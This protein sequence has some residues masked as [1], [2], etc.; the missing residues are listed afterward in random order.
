MIGGFA[1]GQLRLYNSE[2]GMKLVEIAAHARSITALD[3]AS[4]AAM[5]RKP[6]LTVYHQPLFSYLQLLSVSE[7]CT[8]SLWSLP[9]TNN[10][11]V[12]AIG[13]QQTSLV[14]FWVH[15]NKLTHLSL[16]G[17][18]LATYGSLFL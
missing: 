8:L 14:T 3:V 9:M 5:V 12:C 11:K 1:N 16:V 18:A 7:D 15:F 10:P 17:R 6:S 13:S 4:S 2:S